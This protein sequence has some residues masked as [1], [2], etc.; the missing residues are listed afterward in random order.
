MLNSAGG[1][2]LLVSELVLIG[3]LH[4]VDILSPG[5]SS[6]SSGRNRALRVAASKSESPSSCLLR[7]ATAL[8]QT[9]FARAGT[10]SGQHGFGFCAP[11]TRHPSRATITICIDYHPFILL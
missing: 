8:T 10:T 7:L 3:A 9:S 6:S 5:K 4:V 1:S 2:M 11:P